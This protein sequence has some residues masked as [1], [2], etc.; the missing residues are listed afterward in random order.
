MRVAE[1][2]PSSA[3]TWRCMQPPR[4]PLTADQLLA[5]GRALR[6]LAQSLLGADGEDALQE[7]YAAALSRPD[8]ARRLGP[9]LAGTV[10]RLAARWR[11]D[12][13]HRRTRELA[14]ARI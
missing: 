7:G 3:A 6:A 12:D 13:A 11:R 8:A 5:E 4:D 10:R 9:W 14:A 1:S 2:A